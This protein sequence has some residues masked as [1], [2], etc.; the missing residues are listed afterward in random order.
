VNKALTL[1]E[2]NGHEKDS[3]DLYFNR[4]CYAALTNK[5]I[6]SI[7]NDL[8]K[9]ITFDKHGTIHNDIKHDIQ[10]DLATIKDDKQFIDFCN[11]HKIS[12]Q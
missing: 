7:L 6:N 11:Q 5:A 2:N 4:A 10:N 3:S 8:N 12:L 1:I 9:A